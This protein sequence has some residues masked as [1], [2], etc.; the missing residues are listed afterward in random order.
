MRVQPLLGLG[1]DHR[2]DMGGRICGIADDE[3]ARRAR[4][5]LDHAVGDVVLQ[6]QQSQRRAALAGGA[7]RRGHDVVGDLFGQ[8]GGID[9]HRIDAAGLRDQRHDRSILGGERA[10]DRSRDFR[11]AREDDAG[12]IGMRHQH[13]ADPAVARHQMQR[14]R[15]HAGFMQQPDG[16]SRNQRR[17][18]GRLRNDRVAGHQGCRDL[19]QKDRQRKIPRRDRDEDATAAQAEHV[20]L[21]RWSR[22]RL[23]FAEQLAPLRGIVAAEI[24]GFAD[25]RDRI[26]QC[27]AALALQQRD[28]TLPRAAPTDRRP[29]PVPPRASRPAFWPNA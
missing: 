22:H 24:H 16:F 14:G 5:H 9:D 26:I 1:V 11:R 3:F 19:T 23:A 12:D 29:F 21:A 17:L 7:E 27:L 18:F 10:V 4:N 13:A 20:A 28:E 2:A 15:R 6:E 25:F 8:R